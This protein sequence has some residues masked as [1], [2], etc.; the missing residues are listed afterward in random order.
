[1]TFVAESMDNDV[2]TYEQLTQALLW[3]DI[4]YRLALPEDQIQLWEPLQ[5]AWDKYIEARVNLLKPGMIC[6]TQ[7]VIKMKQIRREICQ[8]AQTQT[9]IQGL[10]KLVGFL[11]KF[12]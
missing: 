4:E 2:I 12:C 3:A 1:M 5:K 8:A 10:T 11:L 9:L 7:D 6:T